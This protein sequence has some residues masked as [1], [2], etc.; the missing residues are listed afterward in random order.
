MKE[1]AGLAAIAFLLLFT[2]SLDARTWRVMRDGSADFQTIQPAVNT[3]SPGDTISIG[4]GRYEETTLFNPVP[5]RPWPK[6]TCIGVSVDSLTF[7]GDGVDVVI[8]GPVTPNYT[9]DGPMG[10]VNLTTGTSVSV[11]GMTFENV[12]NGL[13]VNGA[14]KMARCRCRTCENGVWHWYQGRVD[15]QSCEFLSNDDG[16]VAALGTSVLVRY[17]KFT[18]NGSFG[19]DMIGTT[20]VE[21]SHSIFVGNS[22]GVQFEQGSSGTVAHNTIRDSGVSGVVLTIASVADIVGNHIGG[23]IAAVLARTGCTFLGSGNSLGPCSSRTLWFW[24]G[25]AVFQ[26]NHILRGD[27]YSVYCEGFGAPPVTTVTLPNNY[28][29]TTSADSIAAWIWD[30]NDDPG[31]YVN[32]DVE[33]FS[34][35]PVPEKKESMGGVKALFRGRR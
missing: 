29:G 24:G 6:P 3:A 21:V 35:V 32:V 2:A 14:L 7:V 27:G 10:L 17:C 11:E 26:G 23:G 5:G 33:P 12:F 1:T 15:I 30:G 8:V 25:T 13:E 28:W 16:I 4:P 22:T 18:D 19:V 9:A 34:P 20:E 31:L